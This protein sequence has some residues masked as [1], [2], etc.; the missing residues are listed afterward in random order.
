MRESLGGNHEA[1]KAVKEEYEASKAETKELATEIKSLEKAYNANE[2]ELANLPF[3]LNKAE[4]A[5]QNLR[6]EAQKLH[7]EY[8]NAGGRY[9]DVV[10]SLNTLEDKLHTVGGVMQSTGGFLTK[11]VTAPLLL[12]GGAAIAASIGFES[13]FAGVKKTVDELY[14][15]NGNLIISYDDLSNG[16]REMAKNGLPA[17]TT[18][19]AEVAEAAGQLGIQTDNVLAFS[20]TMIDMGESTNLASSDAATALARFANITGMSQNQFSNLGSSIVDLGN[21]FATTESEIVNMAMR[22]AGAGTIVGMSEPDILGLS[23]ALS[24]VGI[25][26]EAGGSSISKLMVNMQLASAKGQDAFSGLQA[27]AERNGIAWESVEKAYVSGGKEL[28]NMSNAL[29]LGNKGLGDLYKSA[30]DAEASLNDFAYVAGMSG[31]EFAQAFQEDAVGAI[32][33]FI[34]GLS[35]AEERGTTAIEM[36]DN[37]G[38]SEVRLR[39]A[40]LRAGGASE[41][42]G[43]AIATSNKA[44]EENVALTEEAEKRYETT[45]SKLRMLKNQVNDVA[46]EFGGP[47]VDA[48]R[49]GIEAATPLIEKLAEM[50]ES[51]SNLDED[52][53]RTIIKWGLFAIAGGPVLSMM[54]N[55]VSGLGTVSGG[56][57]DLLKWYGKVTTPKTIGDVTGAFGAVAGGAT[58]AAG[59]VTTFVTAIGG[60][61]GVLAIGGAALLGWT[62][63]KA[64]G[65]DAWNSAQRTKDWGTDVGE[66]LGGTLTEIRDFST[67]ANGNFSLMTQGLG[68]DVESISTNFASMGE[69]IEASL[70]NRIAKLD[71]LIANLP[72]TLQATLGVIHEEDKKH[73]EEALAEI[74]KNK[75][76]IAEIQEK[77]RAQG[78]EETI[79]DLELIRQYTVASSEAFVKTLGM[80]QA[81]QNDLLAAMTGDIELATQEQAEAWAVSLG[82]QRATLT[83]ENRKKRIA[84][85]EDLV[86]SKFYTQARIDELMLI[87]DEGNRATTAGIDNQLAIIAEKFPEIIKEIHFSNGELIDASSYASTAVAV[88]NQEIIDSATNMSAQIAANA[89]KNAEKLTWMGDEATDWGRKWNGI[90]LKDGEIQTNVR[91]VIRDAGKNN[92]KW[93]AMRFMLHEADLSSNAKTMIGEAGI[94]NGYWDRMTWVEKELVLEDEFS[95]TMFKALEDTEKWNELSVE[96]KTALLYSNTPEVMAQ[97]MFDLGLWDEYE[98]EIKDLDADNYEVL[99]AISQSETA[100]KQYNEAPVEL[101]TLLANDPST[102]TFQESQKALEAFNNLEPE[103]KKLLGE[104][105]V[106]LSKIKAVQDRIDYYNN[107]V[108]PGP[109]RLD[110]DSNAWDVANSANRAINSVPNYSSKKIDVIYNGVRT[111]AQALGYAEGTNNHQGGPMIVNDQRGPLFKELVTYPDGTSF[112]PEGR[113]VLIPDAP[114]GAKVL[115][116]SLTK[117]LIPRYE[118]GIGF[119]TKALATATT[120]PV[121]NINVN[122]PVVREDS[123]IDEIVSRTVSALTQQA[124]LSN[125]FNKGKEGAYA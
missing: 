21:N 13:A 74:Q 70:I 35:H 52:T 32:G 51:F 34:E 94:V 63:W 109:K 31:D 95:I 112:I 58:G 72:E 99:N 15:S 22:L 117:D 4:V 19:I 26:A 54:G 64:W 122:N 29:G 30:E 17:T 103:L 68:G 55:V 98:A 53:Q 85:E 10:D 27:V 101:K 93:N 87:W 47:L 124:R 3:T 108:K 113:N 110:L 57:S 71:E 96:Q 104:N 46:I 118:K 28:K 81:E 62:A 123:D 39:D 24:S 48:L 89:E 40:L 125:L 82:K 9:A 1:T 115:K 14:D 59:H 41:L 73:A 121:F 67:Q 111:G 84:Y 6:N 60:I 36:L 76:K 97:T 102:L 79:L 90:V 8:R 20:K 50:G 7:E 86:A 44:F 45:E 75:E 92:E 77:A 5:T 42:F 43:D 25:E 107:H 65:E 16:I 38:I 120:Q 66:T 114:R 105:D 100:L 2:K 18:E 83:D 33:K 61:P 78:R 116:A 56:F 106:A 80:T 37:M 12:A 88:S 23:A 119:D 69:V 49:D 11:S 91:D